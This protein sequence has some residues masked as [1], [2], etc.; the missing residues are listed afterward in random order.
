MV[1]ITYDGR[2]SQ[3]GFSR[4]R[5]ST[6]KPPILGQVQI[7]D[8]HVRRI[9]VP[10]TEQA[11]QGAFAIRGAHQLELN[12]RSVKTLSNEHHVRGVIFGQ[13][14]PARVLLAAT[15]S[16]LQLV[17]QSAESQRP[18]YAEVPLLSMK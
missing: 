1:R 10:I 3:A 18:T 13:K 2:V 12:A 5:A 8:D 14:T 17:P 9:G 11:L 15:S 16:P 6:V 4:T 7:K